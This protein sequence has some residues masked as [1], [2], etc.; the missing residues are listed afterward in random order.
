MAYLIGTDEAGY[1]PNLGPLVVSCT[2]WRVPDERAHDELYDLLDGIVSRDMAR[3]VEASRIAIADSKSL[4]KSGEG[5]LPLECGVLACLAALGQRPA[6]W[7]EAW[8]LLASESFG[9]IARD[10]WYAEFDARLPLHVDRASV[11]RLADF[12]RTGQQRVGVQLLEIR[13]V[14]VGPEELN[15]E[16]ERMGSKGTV[17]SNVTLRLLAAALGSLRDAPIFAHCDKHG[18]RNRYGPL[19]QQIFPDDL[20]EVHQESSSCSLYRWGPAGRRTEVRFVSKGE[21]FL[22]A[23][24]ASMV[25]KYL[26][27]LAMLAFNAFWQ[28]RVPGLRP[29][30]GYP[31]DARRFRQ[32]IAACQ[33][34]LGI[35]DRLLWRNK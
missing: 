4:Y 19:L 3:D 21:R 8:T 25:S 12:F 26:R 30:A 33:Q 34:Q 16:M 10:A 15:S 1:G 32:D 7:R 22:P 31:L 14:V 5:L 20:V 2:V 9:R 23:A 6:C 28:N 18:G 27:E 35:P 24:L 13:S 11:D 29:T 17:L